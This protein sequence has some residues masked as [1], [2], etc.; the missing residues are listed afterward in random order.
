[1]PPRGYLAKP[2][3]PNHDGSHYALYDGYPKHLKRSI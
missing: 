3:F 1:M 2:E